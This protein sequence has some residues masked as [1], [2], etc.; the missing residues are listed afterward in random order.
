MLH[1]LGAGAP[2]TLFSSEGDHVLTTPAKPGQL[3]VE[4]EGFQDWDHDNG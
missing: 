3:A 2:G 1:I 4:F